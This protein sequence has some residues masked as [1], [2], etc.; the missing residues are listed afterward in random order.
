MEVCGEA[1]ERSSN[2]WSDP[3]T[4]AWAYGYDAEMEVRRMWLDTH[5]GSSKL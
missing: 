4:A 5:N 1:F 3:M 2:Q